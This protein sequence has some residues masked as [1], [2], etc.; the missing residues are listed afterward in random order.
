LPTAVAWDTLGRPTHAMLT[1][2]DADGTKSTVIAS[3]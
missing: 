2:L 3:R 1:T